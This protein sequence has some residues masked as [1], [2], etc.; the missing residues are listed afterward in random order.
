MDSKIKRSE[1]LELLRELEEFRKR[2]ENKNEPGDWCVRVCQAYVARK[3]GYHD[4]NAWTEDLK[5]TEED[6]K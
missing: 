2:H 3:A 1:Y 6:A 4:R 5:K